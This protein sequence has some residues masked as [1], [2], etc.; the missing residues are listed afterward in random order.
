MTATE[1]TIFPQASPAASGTEPIAACTVA[2]GRYAATQNILSFSVR[3]VPAVHMTTPIDLNI[4]P[5][6]S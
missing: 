4:S 2:F 1:S 3:E 6:I 5:Q